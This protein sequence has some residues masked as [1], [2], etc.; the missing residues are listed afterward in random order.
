MTPPFGLPL[1]G[2]RQQVT[3]GRFIRSLNVASA[4]SSRLTLIEIYSQLFPVILGNSK[5]F[6]AIPFGPVFGQMVSLWRAF[7]LVAQMVH[8]LQMLLWRLLEGL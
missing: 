1:S 2:L 7:K 5:S 4:Y 8:S 6:Q 3:F